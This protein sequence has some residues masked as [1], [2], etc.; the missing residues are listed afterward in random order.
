MVASNNTKN[1]LFVT[2]REN[3]NFKVQRKLILGFISLLLPI[4]FDMYSVVR[5]D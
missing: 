4:F 5:K 2:A 3:K 1:I